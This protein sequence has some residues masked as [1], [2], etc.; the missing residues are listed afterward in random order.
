MIQTI[1]K[2]II[3]FVPCY[4]ILCILNWHGAKNVLAHEVG[5]QKYRKFHVNYIFLSKKCLVGVKICD[6]GCK[7]PH[8]LY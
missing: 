1:P 8:G 3:N 6:L 5:I 7:H 4:E 2:F